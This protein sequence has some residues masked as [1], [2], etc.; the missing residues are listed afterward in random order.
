[1]AV[2]FDP[3][4]DSAATLSTTHRPA[5][6][7]VTRFDYFLMA[8]AIAKTAVAN[9]TALFP[10]A[11]CSASCLPLS[12]PIAEMDRKSSASVSLKTSAR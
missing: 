8:N 12:S 6:F 10:A 1:M 7:F 9:L 11:R 2:F 3:R 5:L 4:R